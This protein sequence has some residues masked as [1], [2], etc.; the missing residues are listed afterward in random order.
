M[1]NPGD[2]SWLGDRLSRC[3]ALLG[4]M[5]KSYKRI[6]CLQ[7]YLACLIVWQAL[8]ITHVQA[9][10]IDNQPVKFWTC[11]VLPHLLHLG[12]ELV[13]PDLVC[14]DASV[15]HDKHNRHCLWCG[16][17]RIPAGEKAVQY[18]S[19]ARNI[20]V[21]LLRCSYDCGVLVSADSGEMPDATTNDRGQKQPKSVWWYINHYG[22][23][24]SIWCLLLGAGTGFAQFV[25]N[26]IIVMT[27]NDPSSPAAGGGSGGAQRRRP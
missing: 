23:W 15:I 17:L 4:V 9:S 21:S 25:H 1:I 11:E 14:L 27:P 10:E 3:S 19:A 8:Q 12:T 24:V 18:L 22:S 6:Q 13:Q 20:R 2:W 16:N 5:G 26:V 7:N